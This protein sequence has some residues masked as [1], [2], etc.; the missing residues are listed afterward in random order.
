MTVEETIFPQDKPGPLPDEL[1]KLMT[2]PDEP[3][4]VLPDSSEMLPSEAETAPDE[5]ETRS[6][7]LETLLYEPEALPDEAE[8][9]SDEEE[10]FPGID[11]PAILP[12]RRSTEAHERPWRY[13]IAG[14]SLTLLAIAL[15]AV[16][17]YLARP[18]LEP[19]VS[20]TTGALTPAESGVPSAATPVV[21]SSTAQ[22][23]AANLVDI[24]QA[25]GHSQGSSDAPVI[26]VEYG[27]FQCPYC[28]RHFREVEGRL[29]EAYVQNNKVRLIYK[30]YTILGQESVWAALAS[31]CAADQN[32]FWE[33]HDLVF[34]RQNGENQ[35]A[36]NPD[37]LKA[38]AGELGL[39]TAAFNQ[40]F[41]AQK[42][43][44]VVQANTAEAQQ[45]GI[46]GTPG[47]FVNGTS[48]AGA[49]PFEVFQQ[50]IEAELAKLKSSG[51]GATPF[52]NNSTSTG[53]GTATPTAAGASAAATPPPT[54]EQWDVQIA[55]M[56]GL[57]FSA[58]GR[59]LFIAA[60]DGLHVF[61][62]GV[63]SVPDLPKHDYLGYEVT[64]DGFY[65]SGY[66]DPATNLASPLGLVKSTDGGKTLT[67]LGFA[68]ESAFNLVGV[69]YHNHAIYVFNGV[70]NSKLTLGI[71][72]SLDDGQTWQ[73]SALHGLKNS[74]GRIAVHPTQ[75]NIVAIATEGGLLLS[76]DY[77]NT[78]EPVGES[79]PTI[80][81][82][83]DPGGTLLFF[84]YQQ[85]SA[86][87]LANKKI[88]PL[89]TPTLSAQDAIAY[90]A[91]SPKKI[92]EMA[93]ATFLGDL[94][95]SQDGGQ[96][97]QQILKAGK[98]KSGQ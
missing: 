52:G 95:L 13:F 12:S 74:P 46:R 3:V 98:G 8:A 76:S 75:A 32:K 38:W 41:D 34:S 45:L 89:V 59:Q 43:L 78:F 55:Q 30:H 49:Q 39:D 73:E 58:D 60:N 68:G 11:T 16:L 20:S 87:E 62:D 37:N 47:F 79:G 94:H 18:A 29:K 54:E 40:C 19:V 44:A 35:G 96:T 9:L 22:A 7:E 24:I 57:G 21:T 53:A 36:F 6:D 17:G 81:A 50:T 2:A 72:Y 15:G 25:G 5:A 70:P 71:H 65:S 77:G 10:S 86:Y 1:E 51:D 83:F 67:K 69:G 33:Y 92:E 82:A 64:D 91:V 85:L 42:Y 63:W 84:G 88:L 61:S 66:P 23:P 80:A 56:R 93:F 31:E 27:D 4:V 28:G 48:V 90:I 97:W 26:I 14:M